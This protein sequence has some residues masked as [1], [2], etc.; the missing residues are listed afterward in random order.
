MW[1][2]LKFINKSNYGP[3]SILSNVSKIYERN[4]YNQLYDYFDKN[5]FSKYHS[6]CPSVHDSKNENCSG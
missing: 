2:K 6:G 3:I 4:L 1:R 5:R